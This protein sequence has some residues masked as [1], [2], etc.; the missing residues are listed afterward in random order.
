MPK[1]H[2]KCLQ[3]VVDLPTAPFV[4]DHVIRYIEAFA[5]RRSA[6]RIRRDTFG[7]LLVRYEPARKSNSR[8]RPILF[9]AHMDHPGFVATRMEDTAHVR[10]EFLGGVRRPYF[11]D[12]KIQFY[13][14][15]RWVPATIEKLISAR[16]K[17]PRSKKAASSARSFA[18]MAP[19]EAVI[20]RVKMPVESG[21]P[22]MWRIG[23]STT[24]G[25]RLRARVCDDLAGL[26]AILCMLDTVCRKKSQTATYAFFTRA[27]EVGF[28]GALAAVAQRTVPRRALVVAVENSS[29]IPGVTLGAGPVLRVGDKATVFTPEVTAYCQV[30][31]EQLSKKDKAFRFQRKLMDGGTCES[32]AYCHYGYDATGIC[33]PLVNYH[34]MDTARKKIAA[35]SI[36][37]RDYLNLVR[38]FVALAE[39]PATLAFDG[40]HPG[41]GKRLDSL[42]NK[43]RD[44]LIRTAR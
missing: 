7:N 21:S 38:W 20:A 14:D 8:I 11:R 1:A 9:A 18:I 35:E 27:E 43:H 42:L 24:R 19:P 28:A 40:T 36:D 29:V 44:R 39:A 3:Q 5:A 26:A 15:K 37:V 17:N 41:L 2:L 32:T 4:E 23:D 34:N 10:A 33:L 22:G 13:S 6:L 31:A 30:V 16:H 25:H 12:A